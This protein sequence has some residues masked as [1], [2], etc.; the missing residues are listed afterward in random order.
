M[1][2]VRVTSFTKNPKAAVAT[3]SY[4]EG[5][6]GSNGQHTTR[7]LFGSD[8]L[9]EK[10]LAERMI[11]EAGK[12]T[13]F[14]RL[15]ISPDRRRED[16][17]RDLNLR[18][19]TLQTILRLEERLKREVRFVAA[20]HSDHSPNRHVHIVALI[21]GRLNKEDLL[22]LRTAATQ[23]ALFQRRERDL[24]TVLRQRSAFRP[25]IRV[26]M[27]RASRG[28]IYTRAALLRLLCPRCGGGR[29]AG[30]AAES[31]YLCLFCG[32][33]LNRGLDRGRLGRKGVVWA[34]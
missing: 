27:Q 13:I 15:V 5:R 12:G 21:N 16:T 3:V 17:R 33:R 11:R 25:M 24:V 28:L 9:M 1:A 6:P 4:I 32:F 8:G 23:N 26:S 34:R 20:E 7:V 19:L 14:F 29:M 31:S 2:V 18:E 22:A 10:P 30:T